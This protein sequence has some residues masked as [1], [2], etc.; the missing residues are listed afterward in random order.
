MNRPLTLTALFFFL[1]L[2]AGAQTSPA[3]KP[4]APPPRSRAE[5]QAVMAKVPPQKGDLRPLR[6]VLVAGPKDHGRGEHDYPAW[7]RAWAPLLSKASNVTIETAWQWP[8]P[9]QLKSTDVLVCYFKSPWTAEQIDDVKALHAR[10]GGLVLL[11]WAISPSQEFVKHQDITGL[12][13]KSAQYRHGPIDMKLAGEHPILLG[14]PKPLHF[15]DESYWP[16]LGDQAVVN[17]LGTSDEKVNKTD[18]ATTPIPVMWTYQPPSGKGRSF[19]SILGHYAWTFDDP[20]FR[21][22]IL[23][24]MAWSAGES[25]YRFDSLAIDGVTFA[26][27]PASK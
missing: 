12:T 14:L 6:I 5:V 20:Y 9:E 16:L 7:Q 22:L 8:T 18:E 21:L 17:L 25:P 1:A 2:S 24:G 15:Y 27:E 13:Y 4:H 26:P 11:H 10:G 23:R 3:T 19:V